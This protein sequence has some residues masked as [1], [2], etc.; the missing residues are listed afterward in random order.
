MAGVFFEVDD[1][2]VRMHYELF[3]KSLAGADDGRV[4]GGRDMILA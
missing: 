3:I 1:G 4:Q 2:S